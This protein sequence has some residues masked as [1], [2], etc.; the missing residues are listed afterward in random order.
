MTKLVNEFPYNI[1]KSVPTLAAENIFQVDEASPLLD[2]ERAKLFHTFVAKALFACKRSRCDLQVAVAMLCTR[3]KSPTEEDWKKLFRMLQYIKSSLKDVLVL[4]ADDLSVVKWYVDASFAV[5]PDF[6]SH[7][8]VVQYT[9]PTFA[10]LSV[11]DGTDVR[12]S[13]ALCA[14]MASY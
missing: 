3:V 1:S 10:R 5:H 12:N 6:K 7:T 9:R 14:I 4:R 2:Q 8:G 11:S 13:A